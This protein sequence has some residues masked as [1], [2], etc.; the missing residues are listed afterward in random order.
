MYLFILIGPIIT[1]CLLVL[2]GIYI[3]RNFLLILFFNSLILSMLCSL[4]CLYEVVFLDSTCIIEINTWFSVG[5][6]NVKWSFLFDKISCFLLFIIIFIS[7]LVHFF[8][9][10]YLNEDPHLSRF[11]MLLTLFT[12]FMEVLVTSGNLI[13]FFFGWEGV[14]LMSYLLINFWFTRYGASNAGLMAII[15][16]KVG[17]MVFY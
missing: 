15:Y 8:S 10:D 14:G 9:L 1:L 3:P 13:Q 2:V 16:N 11:L 12:V 5:L 17:D 4:F 7:L 6:L